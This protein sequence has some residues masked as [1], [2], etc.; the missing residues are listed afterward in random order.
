MPIVGKISPQ[1]EKGLRVF[2][3]ARGDMRCREENDTFGKVD[4]SGKSPA[5]VHRRKN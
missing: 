3:M 1:P 4:M 5:Y 2:S